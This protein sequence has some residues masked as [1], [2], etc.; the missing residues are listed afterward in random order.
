MSRKEIVILTNMCMVYD[1]DRVL[2]QDRQSSTWPG[3]AYPGGHVEKHE[4]LLDAVI[5]EVREETGLIVSNLE[6]CGVKNWTHPTEDYR[7]LVF[8]YKTNQ[9]SGELQSSR[10][11]QVFWLDRSDLENHQLAEGFDSMLEVFENPLLTENY[12]WFENGEWKAENM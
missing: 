5:R 1:G 8:L 11:G 6:L 7:Y 3:I 2:V 4:S 10:E 12:F 9:F